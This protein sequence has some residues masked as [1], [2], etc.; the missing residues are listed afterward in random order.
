MQFPLTPIRIE[1]LV[2]VLSFFDPEPE[3]FLCPLL[4]RGE[5]ST[6]HAQRLP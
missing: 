6:A 1:P 5:Y 3:S 2:H 4:S